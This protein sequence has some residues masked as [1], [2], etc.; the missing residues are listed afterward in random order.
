MPDN[1][2]EPFKFPKNLK[3]MSEAEREKLYD[4]YMQHT[5]SLSSAVER[6]PSRV[7]LPESIE[8]KAIKLIKKNP[9]LYRDDVSHIDH[10]R[11]EPMS[12]TR[13]GG[14]GGSSRVGGYSAQLIARAMRDIVRNEIEAGI[15]A[16]KEKLAKMGPVER[17]VEERFSD[18]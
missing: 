7:L 5:V 16:Y 15:L 12:V 17:E 13:G 11:R 8:F 18:I 10:I 14:G 9:Q 3:E 4:D 2:F 1:P 6:N